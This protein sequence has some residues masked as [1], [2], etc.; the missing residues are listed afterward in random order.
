MNFSGPKE[1]SRLLGFEVHS[2]EPEQ[3][4]G[5]GGHSRIYACKSEIGELVVRE[6]KGPQ[7]WWTD[8]FPDRVD[9]HR[10]MDQAWAIEAARTAGV[11]A[12]E[13]LHSDRTK[14]FTV[15]RR[16][17]GVPIDDR[18]EDWAPCPYDEAEFGALLARLH[19]VSPAGWG[20]I[21]D[22]GRALF[23]SWPSFLIAAAQAALRTS[24]ERGALGA[25]LA[26]ALDARWL[27]QLR[28]LCI[29]RP[30]L[31]HMESLGFAN[32]MIDPAARTITGLLDYE[33]CIGGDP[34]FEEV[35]MHFYFEHDGPSPF[36]FE[37]FESGYGE[38]RKDASSARLYRVFPYLDKLRWI[39]PESAR[40]ER[41]RET[42]NEAL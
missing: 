23:D 36:D 34:L 31:L 13:I 17:P 7:G 9:P 21:D 24:L 29:E 6:C 15:Q 10:W 22:A 33:D 32:L 42:L 40:A 35:W 18:Y 8:Y 12:P 39:D 2:I 38:L 16:L 1:L 5:G 11:P 3:V 37:R 27:P 41:Y 26:G 20:P 25:E 30:A 19:A 28:E 14:C 4:T